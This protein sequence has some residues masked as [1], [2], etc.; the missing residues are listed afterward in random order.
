[1]NTIYLSND[2]SKITLPNGCERFPETGLNGKQIRDYVKNMKDKTIATC[3]LYLLREIELQKIE[4]KFINEGIESDSV[5][6]VGAI[7]IL[8][9][10]LEQADRYIRMDF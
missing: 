1:M 5:N 4:A 6:D 2:F 8:D 3:S 10:E 9:R 7:E